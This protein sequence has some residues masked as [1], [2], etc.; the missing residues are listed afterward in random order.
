V[1]E[2]IKETSAPE[3]SVPPVVATGLLGFLAKFTVLKGAQRELWLTFAIKLL[4]ILA[5]SVTNWTLILWL[6]SDLGFND[7]HAFV[8]VAWVWALA[9]TV[10]TL[11]AGSVTDAVGLR[12]TFFL[13]VFVCLIARTVMVFTSIKW[14]ALAG[15][16]FPL[17]IGEALGTPVLIAAT[18]RYSTTR[19]RSISF[20]LIYSIMN[21]GF[22][23]AA[24]IFDYVRQTLGEYGHL[25]FFGLEISTYRTL[26]LVSLGFE[27]LLLP[28]IYFLRRGAEATDEGVRFTAEPVRHATG[29]FWKRIWLTI[30]DSAIDTVALFKRLLGQSGFYR[31]LAFLLLIGFLKLIVM[32]MYYVFPTFGI[33]ELGDGAPIGHLLGINYGLII[34]LAPV[35]GALTQQFSAYRM[36]IVG[37]AICTASVFVMALPTAWFQASANGAIGQWLGHSYLGLKG[38]IHPYYIMTA[39]CMVIYSVGEAF[40]APRVYEYAAAI[41]PKGQ[42]ASYG[43]LSYIPFLIG[44]LLVGTGG[45]LLAAFCPERG[46]RHSG[47]M[48]LIFALAASIAPVG[49]IV[50][51][52]YIRVPEAGRQDFD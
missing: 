47:T 15:G 24:R 1:G 12:R 46:P 14:L 31:L 13:G 48:W 36:V 8:L 18:R 33:R 10:F 39:L 42:E 17:A 22:L 2:A 52:R 7:Q 3:E 40:Y 27:L 26:F 35:I 43:A 4:I 41:A 16:L 30:H 51:R 44:K 29:A 20:S 28:A 23:I 9:M 49:L 50:L 34:L 5:Y 37:G 6:K 25:N 45:W 21:V 19:Q 11:L 38:G 32:S